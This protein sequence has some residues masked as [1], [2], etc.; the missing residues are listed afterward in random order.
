M[1]PRS[2]T[3]GMPF[4]GSSMEGFQAIIHFEDGVDGTVGDGA[5]DVDLVAI[6]HNIA[7]APRALV[8][9]RGQTEI[10]VIGNARSNEFVFYRIVDKVADTCYRGRICRCFAKEDLDA[11]RR[12]AHAF[13]IIKRI[14]A[15]QLLKAAHIVQQPTKPRQVN[16][17]R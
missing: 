10:A 9:L 14:P 7:E 8:E 4:D 16:V 13:G 3:D 15:S 1:V 5:H 2:F 6:A 11:Q 17:L 12:M